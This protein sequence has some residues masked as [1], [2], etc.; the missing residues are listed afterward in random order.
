[1][2]LFQ[3]LGCSVYLHGAR[4][5]LK[6]TVRKL[7]PSFDILSEFVRMFVL[8]ISGLWSRQ[9]G[10]CWAFICQPLC[11]LCLLT[12]AAGYLRSWTLV[13]EPVYPAIVLSVESLAKEKAGLQRAAV[14]D[15]SSLPEQDHSENAIGV[16]A[17]MAH[18]M[19]HNFG[20]SHDSADCCSAS[21][22]DGGCI[23]AAATGWVKREA[24]YR[25]EGRVR[26]ASAA[27]VL[28]LAQGASVILLTHALKREGEEDKEN[29]CWKQRRFLAET[30]VW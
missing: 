19:G 8:F 13:P 24:E 10:G 30:L 4:A 11:D 12:N 5:C 17:T 25:E 3:A 2:I 27:Q 1:M 18:E 14:F 16:A 21:A 22:A 7:L 28:L 23:M 15:L 26:Q 20:M 6:V 9:Q 29:K